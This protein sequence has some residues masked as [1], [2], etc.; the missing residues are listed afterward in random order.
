MVLMSASVHKFVEMEDPL[1]LLVM[2]ETQITVMDVLTHVQLKMIG[3]ALVLLRQQQVL[4][5][6][7]FLRTLLSK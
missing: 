5:L 6:S 2:T 4:A 1:N 7:S 3:H